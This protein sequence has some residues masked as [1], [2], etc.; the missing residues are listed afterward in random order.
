MNDAILKQIVGTAVTAL[1]AGVFLVYRIDERTSYLMG[2]AHE[3]QKHIGVMREKI[4]ALEYQ[5]K[6]DTR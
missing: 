2:M 1:V 6:K 5:C 3:N 4:S